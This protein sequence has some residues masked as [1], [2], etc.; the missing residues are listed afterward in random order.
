MYIT[1]K[2]IAYKNTCFIDYIEYTY[3][4]TRNTIYILC[5]YVCVYVH[6]CV[7][8]YIFNFLSHLKLP[9]FPLLCISHC[10][11]V[12]FSIYREEMGAE[13]V[14]VGKYSSSLIILVMGL[15]PLKCLMVD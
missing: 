13:N 10:L 11:S 6:R 14:P 4:H 7:W 12:S 15:Q 5:L 1:C 9:F 3:T 8:L 2:N